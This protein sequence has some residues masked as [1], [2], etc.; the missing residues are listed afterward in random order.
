MAVIGLPILY[1]FLDLLLAI[2]I[3]PMTN[4]MTIMRFD[5]IN[6]I[7]L[8]VSIV[9]AIWFVAYSIRLVGK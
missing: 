4:D 8:S 1:F 2:V 7:S 9:V 5:V 6:A 3:G